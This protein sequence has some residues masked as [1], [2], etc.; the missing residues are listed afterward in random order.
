[1]T[2]LYTGREYYS[3]PARK[4]ADLQCLDELYLSKSAEGYLEKYYQTLPE[5]IWQGRRTA[6]KTTSAKLQSIYWSLP[7]HLIRKDICATTLRPTLLLL[8]SYT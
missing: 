8:T 5:I 1:M 2:N 3:L 4:A 6:T 7:P